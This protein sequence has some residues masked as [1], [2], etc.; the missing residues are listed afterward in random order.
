MARLYALSLEHSLFGD[1]LLV[2]RW[3]RIGTYGRVIKRDWFDQA[4][5]AADER[6]A[7]KAAKMRRGYALVGRA[8]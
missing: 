1:I 7:L 5:D 3:G 6:E 8:G 2:R 4:N